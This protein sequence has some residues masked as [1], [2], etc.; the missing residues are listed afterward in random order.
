MK[1]QKIMPC[2]WFDNGIDVAVRLYTSVFKN[3]KIKGTSHYT[4]S[5][6]GPSGKKV[7]ETL[8]AV[9]ELYGQEIMALNGGPHF[10]QGPAQSL[11]VTC[12]DANEVNSLWSALSQGGKVRMGLDKYPFAERYGWC[13]DKYGVQW[14]LIFRGGQQSVSPALLFTQD[15]RGKCEEAMRFYTS[16]FENS[17]IENL[18]R[19]EKSKSILHAQFKL[20]GQ[21]FIGFEGPLDHPFTFTPAFSLVVNCDTQQ[22]IDTLWEKLSADKDAEQCGWLKDRFGISWQIV[23][24]MIGEVLLEGAP[25]KSDRLMKAV[26]QMK[27]FD[28]DT[29][30]RAVRG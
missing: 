26:M 18:V 14:Q 16:L 21:N 3:S 30:A 9:F 22:E 2:L 11:F 19:D 23:P 10:K 15:Q 7:G 25:Q 8:T 4:E 24:R 29:L 28:I 20:A 17:K 13:E 1:P 5:A 6:T 12:A 27:K